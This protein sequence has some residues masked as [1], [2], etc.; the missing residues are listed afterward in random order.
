MTVESMNTLQRLAEL[1]AEAADRRAKRAAVAKLEA[2][3]DRTEAS[4]EVRFWEREIAK[5]ENG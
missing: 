5:V 1:R 4:N 2:E 3:A